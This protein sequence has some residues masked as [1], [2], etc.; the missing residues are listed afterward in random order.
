VKTARAVLRSS[1]KQKDGGGTPFSR[2]SALPS[3]GLAVF[4]FGLC[5]F[6]F[7]EINDFD[8]AVRSELNQGQA[9]LSFDLHRPHT[10]VNHAYKAVVAV[11]DFTHSVYLPSHAIFVCVHK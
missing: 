2:H 9:P 5:C 7:P 8:C 11:T 6:C 4:G 1:A 10:L 3:N